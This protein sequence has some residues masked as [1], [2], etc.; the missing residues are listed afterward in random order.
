LDFSLKMIGKDGVKRILAGKF[1]S[2]KKP[3]MQFF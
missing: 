1:S 3:F 2:K